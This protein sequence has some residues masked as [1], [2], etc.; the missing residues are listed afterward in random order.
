M[1]K[2][3]E[4]L[5]KGANGKLFEFAK[6]LRRQATDAEVALWKEIRNGNGLKFRRQHP[7]N[8]FIADFYCHEKNLVIEL[9]G[10]IHHIELIA[11]KD[12]ERTIQLRELGIIVIRF[13]NCEVM[14]NMKSVLERIKQV[15][16]AL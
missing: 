14:E 13:E 1:E 2:H 4:N 7:L 3:H 15:V 10:S 12:V 8:N 6:Q 16:A 5:H 11:A 9:D